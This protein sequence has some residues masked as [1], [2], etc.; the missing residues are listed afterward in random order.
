MCVNIGG[1]E[2]EERFNVGDQ[3]K[4]CARAEEMVIWG[5]EDYPMS[6][7]QL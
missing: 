4:A 5:N 7:G 3:I 1:E 6:C 2:A